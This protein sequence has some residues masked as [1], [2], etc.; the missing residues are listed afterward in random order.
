MCFPDS[1]F[2]GR[3]L[4]SLPANA[5][6]ICSKCGRAIEAEYPVCLECKAHMPEYDAARSAFRYEGQVIG[7]IKKFK[8]GGRYLARHLQSGWSLSGRSILPMRICSSACR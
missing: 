2:C 8:T 1:L 6:F 7:L 3:C 5:G 4:A